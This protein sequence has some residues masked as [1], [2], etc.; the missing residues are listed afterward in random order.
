MRAV[1]GLLV[2]W[3]VACGP[4]PSMPC[5]A[6]GG[7]FGGAGG[8]SGGPGSETV[9]M[10]VVG[11]P[12]DVV[13]TH[14]RVFSCQPGPAADEVL[15]EVLDPLNRKLEHTH[16]G[17]TTGSEFV[18]TVRF[19]PPVPGNYHVSARF[20]PGLGSSQA[21]VLIAVDKSKAPSRMLTLGVHCAALEELPSGLVLC[22]SPDDKLRVYRDAQLLQSLDADDFHI[23]PGMVWTTRL[24]VIKRWVESAG[25]APLTSTYSF[26]T[27][28]VDVGTLVVRENTVVL[29]TRYKV[30]RL[31]FDAGVQVGQT[32]QTV[33]L[34]IYAAQPGLEAGQLI[35][36]S[37]SDPLSNGAQICALNPPAGASSESC[38][39][40]PNGTAVMGADATGIWSRDNT[41]I[42][43]DARDKDGKF[44]GVA[45]RLGGPTSFPQRT[46]HFEG[47][48]PLVLNDG[49][50]Y[51]PHRAPDGIELEQ[52]ELAE[53]FS[54]AA[55][56]AKTARA[57]HPDGRQQLFTR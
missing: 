13:L 34:G 27:G 43:H 19:T 51:L 25:A 37:A 47:T 1:F 24:G 12:M 46:R 11:K 22:L 29:A 38:E 30:V 10:G 23:V 8:F 53:G 45:L 6:P 3:V 9:H 18:T 57:Q 5:A 40:L 42:R 15:T 48:P 55:S 56:S 2:L 32:L 49:R 31:S 4:P 16:T 26:D 28:V 44:V 54:M 17:P 36:F 50:S 20:E 33:V 14:F 21:E 41:G 7:G 52:Y 39:N 35:T